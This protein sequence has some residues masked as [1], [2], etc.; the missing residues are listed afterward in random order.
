MSMSRFI[1][2]VSLA[3]MSLILGGAGASSAAT[4]AF[5]SNGSWIGSTCERGCGVS[6]N[7]FQIGSGSGANDS[8]LIIADFR[9][10]FS[11]DGTMRLAKITWQN[12]A[13]SITDGSF[14]LQYSLALIFAQPTVLPSDKT[15]FTF[16]VQQTPN[17]AGDT[18]GNMNSGIPAIGPFALPGM[19]I[20]NIRWAIVSAG[21]GSTF[22]SVTGSWY[23]PENNT[24]TIQLFA[25][26]QALAVPEP[27]SF[28]ILGA[29]LLGLAA[30]R[31]ARRKG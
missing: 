5:T 12:N 21:A 20:S 29:G 28:A 3:A 22:D 7:T 30:A 24:A 8:R 16:S 10:E 19:I 26:F 11:T 15:G 25:D 4:V 17:P 27:A 14:N 31:R 6:G 2:A 23:N 1:G 13:T 18:I 9:S